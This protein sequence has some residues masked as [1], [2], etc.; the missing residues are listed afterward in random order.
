MSAQRVSKKAL[1]NHRPSRHARRRAVS[2]INPIYLLDLIPAYLVYLIAYLISILP[3]SDT[4][5]ATADSG[6]NEV[7]RKNMRECEDTMMEDT[8]S[9]RGYAPTAAWDEGNM[10]QAMARIKNL[11]IAW[12]FGDG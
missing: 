6:E 10:I 5:A 9:R 3:T 4:D 7:R 12:R 2:T 11:T 1:Y 8:A